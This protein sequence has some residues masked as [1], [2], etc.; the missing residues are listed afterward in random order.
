MQHNLAVGHSHGFS[1]FKPVS[2]THLKK[3]AVYEKKAFFCGRYDGIAAV[4]SAGSLCKAGILP[5]GMGKSGNQA[6]K[7]PVSYTHLDVY[8][9]QDWLISRNVFKKSISSCIRFAE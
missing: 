1:A 8:K 6:R 5:G 7:I 3:G 9:R 2:Y 4:Q